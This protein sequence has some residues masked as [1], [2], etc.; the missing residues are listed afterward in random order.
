MVPVI[1]PLAIPITT[2]SL[3]ETKSTCLI[4]VFLSRLLQLLKRVFSSFSWVVLLVGLDDFGSF[5][6]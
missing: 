5:V 6:I 3:M 4:N 2:K 1:A